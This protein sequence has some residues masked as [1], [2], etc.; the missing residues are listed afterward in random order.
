MLNQ[1]VLFSFESTVEFTGGESD[2][3]IKPNMIPSLRLT[4]LSCG[5]RIVTREEGVPPPITRSPA[6]ALKLDALSSAL[7]AD[8]R[9]VEFDIQPWKD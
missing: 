5:Q 9:V 3:H 1:Y 8:P 7:R 6:S 4:T 2:Y